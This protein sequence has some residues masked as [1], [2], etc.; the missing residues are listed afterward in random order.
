MRSV[1]VNPDISVQRKIVAA[2]LVAGDHGSTHADA[3]RRLQSLHSPGPPGVGLRINRSTHRYRLIGIR[4]Q[5]RFEGL[6]RN[7][8]K[9]EM[10][11]RLRRGVEM[12][13]CAIRFESAI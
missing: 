2:G 7:T 8:S 12:L 6:Q 13:N 5:R 11:A 10:K 3:R 4:S 9:C 1:V